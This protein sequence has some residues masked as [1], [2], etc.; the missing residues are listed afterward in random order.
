MPTSA[1]HACGNPRCRALVPRGVRFCD[2]HLKAHH[3]DQARRRAE[4]PARAALDRQYGSYRWKRARGAYLVEHPLCTVCKRNGRLRPAVI[5]D[6][7]KPTAEGGAFWDSSN[8]QGLCDP[9]HRTKSAR[10]TFG[11][12]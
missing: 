10:E 2:E 1:P 6:H 5:L 3:A 9:C 4:D 7:I 12:G 8:W 11:R